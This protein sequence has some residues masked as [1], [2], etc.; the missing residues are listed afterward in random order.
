VDM[1]RKIANASNLDSPS[2]GSGYQVMTSPSQKQ[3]CRKAHLLSVPR[4][5]SLAFLSLAGSCP[6]QVP[7][8]MNYYRAVGDCPIKSLTKI[9]TIIIP[10]ITYPE[11]VPGSSSGRTIPLSRGFGAI[12]VMPDGYSVAAALLPN[13]SRRSL[14]AKPVVLP[15]PSFPVLLAGHACVLC[16]CIN[17]HQ[18][19]YI[20]A[21][22]CFRVFATCRS[23]H[24]SHPHASLRFCIDSTLFT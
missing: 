23:T 11:W 21:P 13:Q 5:A 18:G 12:F 10:S 6:G 3:L 15:A 20:N 16:A 1:L 17:C 24:S 14:S 22:I 9:C 4:C 8:F 19:V 2:R 7:K